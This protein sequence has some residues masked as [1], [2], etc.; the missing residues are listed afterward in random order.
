MPTRYQKVFVAAEALLLLLYSDLREKGIKMTRAA[1][2][3]ISAMGAFV[4]TVSTLHAQSV[5]LRDQM[6]GSNFRILSTGDL[7]PP[8]TDPDIDV[9]FG[10]NYETGTVGEGYGDYPASIPEAPN[11]QPGDAPR[12]GLYMAANVQDPANLSVVAALP[13]NPNNPAQLFQVSGDYTVQVDVWLNFEKGS[14]TATEVG[15]IY[16]GHDGTAVQRGAGFTATGDGDAA[17]DYPLYKNNAVQ[18]IASGQY[19]P[20]IASTNH[21]DPYFANELLDNDVGVAL[22]PDDGQGL[23]QIST[24]TGGAGILGF[25]WATMTIDVRPNEIGVGTT[26]DPGVATVTL[27]ATWETGDPFDPEDRTI[28]VSDPLLIGTIDNSNGGPVVNMTGPIALLYADLFASLNTSGFNFGIFD[29]LI[30]TTGDAVEL[31]G[32][33]N[34]NGKVDAADYVVWRKNN[35]TSNLLPNDNG[36]GTPIGVSHYNL[37]RAN[38]GDMA[39]SGSGSARAVPEPATLIFVALGVVAILVPR[40]GRYGRR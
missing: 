33:Y 24:Y 8:N 7:T 21:A 27:Q 6:S 2:H 39:G 25:R 16:V 5:L 13:L 11:T 28:I 19:N 10:F 31:P 12:T 15:G 26:T 17:S 38:F 9:R 30:V 40:H 32:D 23:S 34:G 1:L 20:V 36:L 37:W 3:S 29:N 4:L 18:T 14:A 22:E 35:G